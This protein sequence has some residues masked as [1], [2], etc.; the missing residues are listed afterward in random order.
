MKK[1]FLSLL[2]LC[3]LVLGLAAPA[4]AAYSDLAGHWAKSYM[5]EMAEK[6]YLKGYEDGTMKP[7]Q[8][9]TTLE[10]L[11]LM[12]RFYRV[13]AGTLQ[14]ILDDK[15]STVTAV[16]GADYAWAKNELAVCLAAGIVS[17]TE[18]RAMKLGSNIEKEYLSVL[19]VRAMGQ[20]AAASEMENIPLAFADASEITASRRAYVAWLVYSGIVIGDETNKFQPRSHVTRAVVATMVSRA[21]AYMEE[22]LLASSMD[23]YTGTVIVSGVIEEAG[24]DDFWLRESNGLLRR[25]VILPTT[26]VTINGIDR[27]IS[28]SNEGDYATAVIVNGGLSSVAVADRAGETWVRGLLNSIQSSG[29]AASVQLLDKEEE[30][31]RYIVL[32]SAAITQNGKTVPA[33]GLVRGSY[34]VLRLINGTV[35][36]LSATNEKLVLEGVVN[37]VELGSTVAMDVKAADGTLFRLELDMSALPPIYRGG[38]PVGIDRVKRGD[39]VTAEIQNGMVIRLIATG[40]EVSLE[41]RITLITENA[42]GVVWTIR[43]DS[44]QAHAF[45]LDPGI[46][47]FSDNTEI[48]WSEVRVGNTVGL[49]VYEDMITEVYVKESLQSGGK[50]SGTVLSVSSD[51]ITTFAGNKL[52]YITVPSGNVLSTATGG[53]VSLTSIKPDT[54]FVAYGSY[55]SATAF[56]ATMVVLEG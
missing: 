33:S 4:F 40:G 32:S 31:T 5:E 49:V 12:S 20:A 17:E 24:T 55:S 23:S 8:N 3:G 41:G 53:K 52:I 36:E 29:G 10:A 6:G 50:L 11:V 46:S 7:D 2:L 42:A 26:E 18:L 44:N 22:H 34:A 56:T 47:C 16:A 48:P 15:Q 37:D 21:L 9:I 13:D 19:L 43:D 28:I 54:P 38:E 39:Q 27:K 35:T 30:L 1:R 14:K 51:T 45:A 25:C